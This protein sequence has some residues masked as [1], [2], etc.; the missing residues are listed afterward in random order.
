[1]AFYDPAGCRLTSMDTSYTFGN[2]KSGPNQIDL[3]DVLA[4]MIV[5]L[6]AS[7]I[8]GIFSFSIDVFGG[9]DMM[10]PIWTVGGADL[11]AALFITLFGSVWIV[12]TNIMNGDTSHSQEAIAVFVVALV[13][14]ILTVFM[15]AFESLVFWNDLVQL[16]FFIYT[17]AAVTFLS[18]VA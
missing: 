9:Y 10:D 6:G 1:M 11:S 2:L 14:P 13:A 12:L 16:V 5:P 3:I 17:T 15:P 18:Y 7:M 8:F 4:L